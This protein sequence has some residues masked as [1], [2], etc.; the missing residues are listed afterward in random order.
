MEKIMN[1][2]NAGILITK[3]LGDTHK[4]NIESFKNIEAELKNE[5]TEILTQKNI[6][7]KEDY[8]NKIKKLRDKVKNYRV[9]RKKTLDSLNEKRIAATSELLKSINPI[10]TE[11]ADMNSISIIM[12]KKNIIIGKKELDITNDILAIVNEKIKNINID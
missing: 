11:Y 3:T 10:L 5:E 7:D 8:K 2:S 1:Q 12:Q 6:L 9:N 4:K